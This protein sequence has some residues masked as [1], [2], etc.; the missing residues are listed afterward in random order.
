M[1]SENSLQ[2][3]ENYIA[4]L[5]GKN[6]ALANLAKDLIQHSP[7]YA[8]T[9]LE[10][11]KLRLETNTAWKEIPYQAVIDNASATETTQHFIRAYEEAV[12]EFLRFSRMTSPLAEHPEDDN[13]PSLIFSHTEQ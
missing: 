12:A 13:Q 10:A 11:T 1:T 7:D 2:K 3:L 5:E 9:L 6:L 8:S 4:K